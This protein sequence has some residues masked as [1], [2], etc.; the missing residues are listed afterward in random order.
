MRGYS[1]SIALF[2]NDALSALHMLAERT[3]QCCVT[4]PP[5]LGL[6]D[7]NL[8]PLIWDGHSGCA[9]KWEKYI[10][11]GNTWGTPNSGSTPGVLYNAEHTNIAIVGPT[12]QAFC[13]KCG[14]WRGCLGLEPNSDMYI[15]HLVEIF[16]EVRRVLTPSGVLWLNLGDSYN[17]SGFGAGK[18]R[19]GNEHGQRNAVSKNARPNDERLKPKDLMGIPWRVALALQADGWWLRSDVIWNK[20]NPIPESVDDR[21]TKAHEYVFMLTK[22][23]RCYFDLP[24]VREGDHNLRSVWTVTSQPYKGAHFA[25]MPPEI[26][27]RCILAGSAVGDTVL[28]PFMGSG[29]TGMVANENGR[30]FIGIEP[31]AEYLKLAEDRIGVDLIRME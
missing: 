16:R 17:G 22:S 24:A 28:D 8:E 27:R 29:T 1:V 11:P 21:P 15:A 19:K 26:A 25:T 3:V 9:H 18:A 23:L 7:Y 31:S 20:P 14:A 13:S 30:S 4:S 10:R 2:H 6:R 5:Y 12:E